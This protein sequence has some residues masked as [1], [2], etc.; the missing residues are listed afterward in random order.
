MSRRIGAVLLAGTC[1]AVAAPG[2]A[3]AHSLVRPA[4]ALVSYLSQDA[5]SLNTLTVSLEGTRI[6][7]R[8]PTVDGGMDPGT[9]TPGD[10]S[11][12]AGFVVETFCPRSGVRRVRLDL[13]EREDSARVT[14]PIAATLLGGPGADV[15]TGGPAG[16]QLAGDT[17][18][19]TVAG[20]AG[21][22]V[23]DGGLGADRLDGGPG[24]DE[25][26][27]RDGI[28]DEVACGDGVDTVLADTLDILDA[29]C[30]KPERL[31]VAPPPGSGET[32][33]DKVA[34]RVRAASARVQRVS[35]SRGSLRVIAAS[36]EAGTVA[37]SGV[38]NADG[39]RLGLVGARRRIAVGGGGAELR[40]ALTRRQ[41]REV[42]VTLRRKRRVTVRLSV[43]A[44]DRAGNS[45]QVDL[46]S[47]RLRR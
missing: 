24:N 42:L 41:L 13:G 28:A 21:D 19:D 7:F 18:D 31:A 34:P 4:G 27:V 9:C 23:L 36:S 25:L 10:V 22:D 8:D 33:G 38:L 29:G 16:D 6:A 32:A 11:A 47:I 15:L 26:R 44:T 40:F 14:A 20:G 17:G 35:A 12:G 37:T 39:L 3:G 46:P 5:T 30:E 43:V 2:A 1:G 45:R